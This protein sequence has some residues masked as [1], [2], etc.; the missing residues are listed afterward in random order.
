MTLRCLCDCH[1]A[2]DALW[3]ADGV[4]IDNRIPIDIVEAAIACPLCQNTHAAIFVDPPVPRIEAPTAAEREEAWT[5]Y[6]KQLE[7]KKWWPN[8]Q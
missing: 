8:S 3:R 4:G 2:P 7:N 5:E 1:A 6:A